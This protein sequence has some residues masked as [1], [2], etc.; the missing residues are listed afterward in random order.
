MGPFIWVRRRHRLVH[1]LSRHN[2]IAANNFIIPT[3]RYVVRWHI[4]YSW[5]TSRSELQAVRKAFV[6]WNK[7]KSIKSSLFVYLSNDACDSVASY[8][9]H[10]YIWGN[11]IACTSLGRYRVVSKDVVS[12]IFVVGTHDTSEVNSSW[13]EENATDVDSFPHQA[14]LICG[15]AI[16]RSYLH[17]LAPIL[18]TLFPSQT[19]T[20]LVNAAEKCKT[21]DST[22]WWIRTHFM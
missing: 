10:T 7:A 9:Q 6:A 15:W 18:N 3:M 19:R 5:P 12:R 16:I 22:T 20:R 21:I 1:D 13:D 4:S 11:R 2:L 8:E 14:T 17:P